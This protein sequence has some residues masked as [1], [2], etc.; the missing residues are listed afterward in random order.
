MDPLNVPRR[1]E[2]ASLDLQPFCTCAI[3]D[4]RN[5]RRVP[6]VRGLGRPGRAVEEDPYRDAS[7]SALERL[8]QE[9]IR[10]RRPRIV[11]VERLDVNSFPRRAEETEDSIGVE[12][13]V[14]TDDESGG[15]ATARRRRRPRGSRRRRTDGFGTPAEGTTCVSATRIEVLLKGLPEL[16]GQ[17]DVLDDRGPASVPPAPMSGKPGVAEVLGGNEDRAAVDNRVL[18]ME[19]AVALDDVVGALK[20]LNPRAGIHQPRDDPPFVVAIASHRRAFEEHSNPH[21]RLSTR[22][23]GGGEGVAREGVYADVK[24]P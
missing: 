13:V 16:A 12:G 18:R 8:L 6:V 15:H 10:T 9:R 4:A 14:G 23:K 22:G 7:P 19:I 17:T 20:P 1:R 24:G 11:E 3:V 5:D 21:P 2:L